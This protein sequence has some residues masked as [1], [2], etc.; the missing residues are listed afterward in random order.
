[1]RDNVRFINAYTDNPELIDY[2]RAAD[3]YV[4]PYLNEAQ[5]TSGTLSYAAALGKPII[6]T[7]YWHAQELLADGQGVI[8]P[9]GDADAVSG[10]AIE[11][12]SDPVALAALRKRIY[13]ATRETVWS[14]LA[15]TAT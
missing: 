6:S 5:I 4:T 3:I 12:L 7:P 11:L 8:T 14:R 1:M 10:A 15:E 13:D 9:F 2:L